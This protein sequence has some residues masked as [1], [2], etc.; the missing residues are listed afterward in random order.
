M[1]KRS[2]HPHGGIALP[3]ADAPIL[4][5]LTYNRISGHNVFVDA[6][7]RGTREVSSSARFAPGVSR[8]QPRG[9]FKSATQ[10][11]DERSVPVL[12]QSRAT[13]RRRAWLYLSG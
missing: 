12:A 8:G 7:Y 1:A 5:F 10:L 11:A 9:L 3:L 6:G 13:F 4:P 2:E